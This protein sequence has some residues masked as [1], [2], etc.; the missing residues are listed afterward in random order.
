MKI[1]SFIIWAILIIAL[2]IGIYF[3]VRY[4]TTETP[5]KKEWAKSPN[6]ICDPPVSADGYSTKGIIRNINHLDPDSFLKTCKGM[7]QNTYSGP[8][9]SCINYTKDNS[10]CQFPVG[11]SK[12]PLENC[13]TDSGWDNYQFR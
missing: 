1:Y 8:V 2:S 10:T 7:A 6:R 9:T 5:D 4:F 3:I 11:C 13:T 12:T